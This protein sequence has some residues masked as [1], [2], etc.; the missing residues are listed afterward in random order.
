MA[1]DMRQFHQTFFEESL[2]ALASMETELLRLEKAAGD[3]GQHVLDSD[4]GML[5]TLVCGAHSNKCV[6]DT[7]C[8][9]EVGSF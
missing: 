3:K 6:D 9:Y 2:E 4:P 1:I 8:K 7:L 5:N